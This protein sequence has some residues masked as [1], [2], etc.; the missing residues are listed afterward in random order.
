MAE[1]RR[2][3][4]AKILAEAGG[5]KPLCA[6]SIRLTGYLQFLEKISA[7]AARTSKKLTVIT[8]TDADARGCQLSIVAHEHPK[9][10]FKELPAAG[11]KCDFREPNLI[12]AART[13]FDNT[14]HEAWCFARIFSGDQ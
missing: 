14:F 6:K 5:M 7:S 1:R 10:L 2:K 9:E 13:P 11:V 12:R 4:Y 3:K 8:A